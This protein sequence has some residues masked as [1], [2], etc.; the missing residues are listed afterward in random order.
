LI[1]SYVIP[2][3]AKMASDASLAKRPAF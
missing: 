3:T 1:L 2:N